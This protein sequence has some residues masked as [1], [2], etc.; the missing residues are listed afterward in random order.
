MVGVNNQMENQVFWEKIVKKIDIFVMKEKKL[1]FMREPLGIFTYKQDNIYKFVYYVTATTILVFVSI[2]AFFVFGFFNCFGAVNSLN[3]FSLFS[4]FF[5]V[6][7]VF[8][9]AFIFTPFLSGFLLMVFKDVFDNLKSSLSDFLFFIHSFDESKKRFLF[10]SYW[11]NLIFVFMFSLV[12]LFYLWFNSFVQSY[13]AKLGLFSV[14]L[15]IIFKVLF[16]L[17]IFA[18]FLPL[19]VVFGIAFFHHEKEYLLRGEQVSQNLNLFDIFVHSLKL[20]FK[21][22][23]YLSQFGLLVGIGFIMV[24]GFFITFPFGCLGVAVRIRKHL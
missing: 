17:G 1:R 6:L 12:M 2:I 11:V 14:V 10:R 20:Y 24:I 3:Q 7:S 22:F 8:T 13:V 4:I 5:Y 15:L 18:L 16:I 21:E 9:T 19:L 23:F